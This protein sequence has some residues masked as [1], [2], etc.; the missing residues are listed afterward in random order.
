MNARLL[1]A[2]MTVGW[3]IAGCGQDIKIVEVKPMNISFTKTTQAE[4]I[5]AKA[6]EVHGGEIPG[7]TFTY[8]SENSGVAT[9]DSSGT[10]K[11]AGNGST[12]I[13]ARAPNGVEGESFVKVCLPKELICH[14]AD[15]LELKVGTAAP[16]KCHVTNCRDE[17]IQTQI[18]MT[19]TDTTMVLKEGDNV[20]IG[21][22]VGDTQIGVKVLD[23]TATVAVHVDEQEFLPGMGPGSMSA[24]KRGGGKA[25][26]DDKDPYGTGGRFDHIIKGMSGN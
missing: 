4:K 26:K 9:V 5:K 11:P 18:E 1:F 19:P 24:R 22:K 21:L 14:P 10:V 7:V 17:K 6:T 8:R 2:V 12:A 16:I 25:G 23:M 15:K 20:F 3:L 13:I